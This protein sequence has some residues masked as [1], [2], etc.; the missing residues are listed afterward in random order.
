MRDQ[1]PYVDLQHGYL[2]NRRTQCETAPH[3]A[4]VQLQWNTPMV[5]MLAESKCRTSERPPEGAITARSCSEP[6]SR[7]IASLRVTSWS[8]KKP[9]T[10][11]HAVETHDEGKKNI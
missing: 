5:L 3:H 11:P 6:E 8:N 9:F 10:G 7:T 2:R 1:S 4:S